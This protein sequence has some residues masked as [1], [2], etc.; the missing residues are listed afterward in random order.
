M[1]IGKGYPP[2]QPTKGFRGGRKLPSG[3]RGRAPAEIRLLKIYKR[4]RRHLVAHSIEFSAHSVVIIQL[5]AVLIL[6]ANSHCP[7]QCNLTIDLR[8]LGLS[9]AVNWLLRL[10]WGLK[11]GRARDRCGQQ[12]TKSGR[13]GYAAHAFKV[14]INA[15]QA[16]A[17][18]SLYVHQVWC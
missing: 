10:A 3:V 6:I 17:M 7:T 2:P 12:G 11:S 5:I 16:T 8:R 14:T 9:G 18:L 13:A 1:G 4:R 15:R